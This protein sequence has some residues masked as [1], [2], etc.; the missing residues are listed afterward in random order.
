MRKKKIFYR[1]C[2]LRLYKKLITFEVNI[3]ALFERYTRCMH[4]CWHCTSPP[5]QHVWWRHD[6][7]CV[8][9]LI[10]L[11][12]YLFVLCICMR[13]MRLGRISVKIITLHLRPILSTIVGENGLLDIRYHTHSP[14][15][16]MQIFAVYSRE[17]RRRIWGF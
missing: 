4:A 9:H 6:K 8:W 17:K 1:T 5:R 7:T 15:S 2:R 3:S 10:Y 14:L 16:F 11:L 13:G 12:I